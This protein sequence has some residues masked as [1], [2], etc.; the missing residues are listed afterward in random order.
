MAKF[1]LYLITI[2]AFLP[3]FAMTS[4]QVKVTLA[5]PEYWIEKNGDYERCD[6]SEEAAKFYKED[7]ERLPFASQLTLSP[8]QSY[9][10]KKNILNGLDSK[11]LNLL[12]ERLQLSYIY[13]YKDI[14]YEQCDLD[15]AGNPCI[16][17][18][19]E[20]WLETD[21]LNTFP[22]LHAYIAK[23]NN[24]F[25]GF[26]PKKFNLLKDYLR[27][28]YS[29][30][31]AKEVDEKDRIEKEIELSFD[32]PKYSPRK[33]L[34]TVYVSRLAGLSL[35]EKLSVNA[36]KKR[37]VSRKVKENGI[38][39]ERPR[40]LGVDE[41]YPFYDS[42]D[43]IGREGVE[44]RREE[45]KI[46]EIG[47][48]D[49]GENCAGIQ[50]SLDEMHLKE[51]RETN[52]NNANE[53][54]SLSYVASWYSRIKNFFATKPSVELPMDP[55]TFSSELAKVP[56]NQSRKTPLMRMLER[57]QKVEDQKASQSWWGRCK[58][59]V[60]YLFSR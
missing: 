42:L 9:L 60:A 34:D 33:L 7:S 44:I 55:H 21:Y 20:G 6:F 23:N 10:S 50:N 54:V 28:S 40:A 24:I 17:G 46:A 45:D 22:K 39:V 58:S 16:M 56:Q 41:I 47:E 25:K 8:M 1:I 59:V 51:D 49:S 14:T 30:T 2:T 53:R 48:N 31:Y 52:F 35:I 12:K 43:E 32:N 26:D 57:A 15:E 5:A 11:A 37:T 36:F 4:D 27:L 38:E 18:P 3:L 29:Y 19:R 13:K